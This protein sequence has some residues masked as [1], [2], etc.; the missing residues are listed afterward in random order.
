FL[1]FFT[2]PRYDTVHVHPHESPS[3]MTVP[4]LLLAVPAAV[5]GFVGFPPED[6]PLHHFLEPVFAGEAAHEEP[7]EAASLYVVSDD[8]SATL[9]RSQ[10][11]GAAGEEA[12]EEGGHHVSTATTV[13]F[14]II[15]T[16]VALAGI[17]VAYLTYIAKK[18]DPVK[19]VERTGSTYS[20]LYNKWYFD[21]LYDRW[22]VRPAKVMADTL[23]RV[24]DVGIIDGTVNGVAGLIGAASQRVRH[25]QT[26]LVANYAL[27]IA[28]GMVVIVGV[29][30]AAFSD[31]LR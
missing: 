4:L 28:L 8:E 10:E 21:E 1:T 19:V 2:A 5:V 30:L 27:A 22:F 7:A 31:L 25:V 29:Y 12:D 24:V 15:S 6:G 16:I 9:A 13:T 18:I 11:E 14:G 3:V 20:F 23:W 26:G 17:A